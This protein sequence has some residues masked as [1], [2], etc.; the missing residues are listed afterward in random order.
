MRGP[1]TIAA[2]PVV[3]H[4]LQTRRLSNCGSRAQL[5]CGMWDLPR[6]GLEPVSP[7]LAGRFSTTA[8]PGKPCSFF[9]FFLPFLLSRVAGRVLVLQPGVGPEPPRWEGQVQ[10][11][12]PPETSR[13]HVIS[14]S[15]S[16]PRDPRL[17]TKTQ[18]H[19]MASKLQCLV[20]HVKQLARQEHKPTH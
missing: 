18:L 11:I 2:S 13:P 3:E 1:L 7:A 12:G 17:N 4:K 19:P 14:I 16:S 10:D 5:L 6:L 9:F 20:L 15:E 8:P